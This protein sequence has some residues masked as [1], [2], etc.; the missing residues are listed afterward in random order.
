MITVKKITNTTDFKDFVTFPF[1]LYNDNPYWVPPIIKD[2]IK[3]FNPNNT[4]FKSVDAEF[5]L[6]YKNN[7]IVG[8]IATIINWTEV[9]ELKKRKVRF[10]WFDVIDDVEVS[11]LLIDKAIEMANK[12]QLTHIEGP[13]GFSN[14]DKAGMLTFGFDEIPTMIGLYNFPYYVTHLEELGFKKEAEWLEFK[15]KMDNINLDKKT[16]KIAEMIEQRYQLKVLDFKSTRD[17]LPYVD[18]MFQLLNTSYAELQSFV[19]IQQFQIDH[20]KEKYI[21]FINPQFIS[22]IVNQSGK[23][24][25]FA[26]TMPSFSRAF[27]KAKG[28]LFPFGF[29]HLLKAKNKN[30]YGEYYLIGVNPEYQNKGVTAIIFREIQNAMKKFG[31]KYMETNPLL[32]EN[33]KVQLLWKNFDPI[34]HKRRKTFRLDL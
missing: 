33:S 19:P 27:Q 10:G 29:I 4:I 17:I 14:M 22:C 30:D 26:I 6:A 8:R 2:E 3:S 7:Q 34:I 13:M 9:N 11:R 15:I 18:E 25:A 23:M 32:E 21:P 31:I 1:R 24:I 20:Y 5:Y 16:L 28:K 12:N